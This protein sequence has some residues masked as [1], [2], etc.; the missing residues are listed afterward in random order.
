MPWIES[1]QSLA[2]HKKLVRLCK[3]LS[4]SKPQA[5][6][7]LHF[8][9]WWALDGASDGDLSDLTADEIEGFAMWEGAPGALH[10]ALR[11]CGWIDE[12]G[13]IHDWK[14]Y[15]G[16]YHVI[17]E[18]NR[19]RQAALRKRLANNNAL[20]TRDVTVTS[21]LVTRESRECNAQQDRTG[22]DQTVPQERESVA[23]PPMSREEYDREFSTRPWSKDFLEYWWNELDGVCHWK[24][25]NC[26]FPLDRK[27]V[28]SWLAN[29]WPAWKAIKIGGNGSP[30]PASSNSSAFALKTQRE[31]V[32]RMIKDVERRGF[33]D[34][35]G[36]NF[37]N[38]KDQSEWMNLRQQLKE[39]DKQLVAL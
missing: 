22:Q 26:E 8:L 27:G 11:E 3:V 30:R 16:R 9:W 38:K 28:G 29:R 1:H 23:V 31:A 25:K 13:K 32:E 33:E 24:P 18:G 15:G 5:V 12:T 19:R 37:E 7:H 2:N 39:I 10:S 4:I 6:G 17:K 14:D 21:A 35:F 20:V 36:M 34:A